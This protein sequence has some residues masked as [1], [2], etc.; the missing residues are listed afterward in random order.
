MSLFTV[1]DLFPSFLWKQELNT[2][3]HKPSPTDFYLMLD[4]HP[5]WDKQ[6]IT[7]PSYKLRTKKWTPWTLPSGAVVKTSKILRENLVLPKDR[8]RREKQ[9]RHNNG[10][11]L[12]TGQIVRERRWGSTSV[13]MGKLLSTVVG[14]LRRLLSHI[15]D[16][17]LVIVPMRLGSHSHL[18]HSNCRLAQI[19]RS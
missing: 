3:V 5:A 14:L 4:F 9:M 1:L 16:A 10:Q 17:V 18:S 12:Y 19:T 6:N 2:G 15:Y 7:T 8:T 11:V 13:K